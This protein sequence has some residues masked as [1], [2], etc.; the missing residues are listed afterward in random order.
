MRIISKFRDYY[1]SVQAHGV[2][3]SLVFQRKTL[4]YAVDESRPTLE[5]LYADMEG[6]KFDGGIDSSAPGMEPF[7]KPN[8]SIKYWSNGSRWGDFECYVREMVVGVCGVIRP[9]VR[10]RYGPRDSYGLDDMRA[11]IDFAYSVEEVDKI[12]SRFPKA[13]QSAYYGKKK[14]KKERQ[15]KPDPHGDIHNFEHAEFEQFFKVHQ[16]VKDDRLFLHFKAPIITLRKTT[17]PYD[18]GV[19]ALH[20]NDE[21]NKVGYVKVVDPFMTYQEIAMYISGVLGVGEPDTVDISD[22]D[23]RDK[24]G[25]FD[26]SFKKDPGVK[27]PRRRGKKRGR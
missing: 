20:I 6:T 27:K 1:D 26:M 22:E 21:L 14:S 8:D 2:D 3:M 4:L 23:M 18:R 15:R 12:V 5:R 19:Q 11:K 24:K 13:A 25:F 9:A 16:P 7:M 17:G 10:L